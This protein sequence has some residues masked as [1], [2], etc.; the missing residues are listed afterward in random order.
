M[1]A[2]PASLDRIEFCQR[3]LLHREIGLKIHVGRFDTFMTKP[4]GDGVDIDPSLEEMH[5]RGVALMPRAALP[6]LD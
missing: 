6:T 5:S 2:F 4:Q 1:E 3:L